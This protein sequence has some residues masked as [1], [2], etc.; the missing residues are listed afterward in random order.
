MQKLEYDYRV[1]EQ[2]LIVLKIK[3]NLFRE[4]LFKEEIQKTIQEKENLALKIDD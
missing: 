1:L 4:K 2:E 3:K